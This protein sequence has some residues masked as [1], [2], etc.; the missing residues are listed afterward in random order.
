[1]ETTAHR[2]IWRRT[3][4]TLV[5]DLTLLS[6]YRLT[7]E[8]FDEI[9][10]RNDVVAESFF[11]RYVRAWYAEALMSIVRR[12]SDADQRYNSLRVLLEDMLQRGEA[13]S[14]HSLNILFA[15]FGDR[16]P[17]Q[18]YFSDFISQETYAPFADASGE[19]LDTDKI[20]RGIEKLDDISWD[21]RQVI[22]RALENRE[23]R[24]LD[25]DGNA[26]LTALSSGVDSFEELAKPYVALLAGAPYVYYRPADELQWTQIF[27]FPWINRDDV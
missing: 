18:G 2:E 11:L 17:T 23:R 15:E 4:T 27:T 16:P 24:G 20:S 9:A 19:T 10:R 21:L 25:A 26:T 13:Y 7:F 1:L 6:R 5:A 3:A 12:Q 8:R 14:R 22:E